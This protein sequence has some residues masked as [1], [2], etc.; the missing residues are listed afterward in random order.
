MAKY[1]RIAI[2]F[3]FIFMV[4]FNA[5]AQSQTVVNG[6]STT[7]INF[8]GT[9]CRYTWVNNNQAIGLA[10]SGTGNIAS[11][12]AV[13]KGTTPITATITA[14]PAAAGY[15]YIPNQVDNTVSVID[16]STNVVIKTIAVGQQP[17]G[18]TIAPDG[19]KAYI[20]NL[21]SKTL[22]VINT[23]TNTVT[24][25]IPLIDSKTGAGYVLGDVGYLPVTG[26]PTNTTISP[27]G[28]YV[29]VANSGIAYSVNT[30][31]N[32][33]N[34]TGKVNVYVL[35]VI[36][37]ATGEVKMIS[38]AVNPVGLC[39][40][41]DGTILYV[42]NGDSNVIS[43]IDI[44]KT[45]TARPITITGS[46][47]GSGSTTLSNAGVAVVLAN[48]AVPINPTNNNPGANGPRNMV[49]SPDGRRLYTTNT[50]S[51]SVSVVNTATYA[52]ISNINLSELPLGICISPDGSKLYVARQ[53]PN[54][55]TVI[56]TAD[57]SIAKTYGPYAS[58]TTPSLSGISLSPDGNFLY[59]ENSI[60]NQVIAIDVSS[61]G[62]GAANY[63]PVGQ[64][65]YVIGNFVSSGSCS[66]SAVTFTITVN[67]VAPT[68]SATGTLSALRTVYGTASTSTQLNVSG[69]NLTAGILVTPPNGFEVSTD[70]IHFSNTVTIGTTGSIASTPVY[71]R[72]AATSAAGNYSG[73]ITLSSA[74]AS[75]VTVNTAA[76]TVV[77]ASLTITANN[78]SKTYG[79]DNPTLTLSYAG[80][81]NGDNSAKLTSPVIATTTA[82]ATSPTGSYPI[83]ASGAAIA[84]YTITYV[85][86]TLTITP[87]PAPVITSVTPAT[88]AAGTTV[89]LAGSNLLGATAVA[90]GGK[91]ASSFTV[92][93]AT[94][95]TAVVAVGASNGLSVTTATGTGNFTGFSFVPIPTISA[96]GLTTVITGGSVVLTASPGTGGYTYQW[97]K[98]G[99]A[100]NGAT[101]A[102]YTATAGGAYTVALTLNN[103]QQVSAAITVNVTFALPVSNFKITNTSVTCK[104][105]NNGTIGITATQNLNY[106]A[107]ITGN[108]LNTTYPFTTSATISNLAAGTYN[109]CLTV[110]GQPGYQQCF[111]SV[112][113]EPKDLSLYSTIIKNTDQAVLS[114]SGADTYYITLNGVTTATTNNQL[115]VTLKNGVNT[116]AVSSDKPCQGLVTENVVIADRAVPF[117]NPFT[118]IINVNLGAEI[119]KK[120]DITIYNAFNKVVH[121]K[122]FK[123]Q[124]GLVQIDAGQLSLGAFFLQ[125][126]ADGQKTIFKMIKK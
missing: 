52:V 102:N 103:L 72:L 91:P 68:I 79:A 73:N 6:A 114:L 40:S 121:S 10:A 5:R 46:S 86:G 117:P 90:F 120:A 75:N 19:S 81:V 13:N 55:V 44:K 25:T 26:I 2:A 28:K 60:S 39:F 112:I 54:T 96:S 3:L 4:S 110:A 95:I 87:A 42:S 34:V 122:T 83:T 45:P 92:N 97:L 65:P 88:A 11:F 67:P 85:N 9:G 89:T 111:T 20:T 61:T 27:D 93:S 30:V 104:G 36:D 98:D 80:F 1:L 12:T 47:A 119:V 63:I 123:N 58:N 57:N 50:N 16:L 77:P 76:S 59:V 94:S 116:L 74:G 15:A 51:G 124:S 8:T 41:P 17:S 37:T 107:T 64:G 43:V 84:N 48:F 7:A 56:N 113:T 69:A 35:Y 38:L 99:V 32:N 109:V 53:Y 66:G 118:S 22:S 101:S 78:Q 33:N 108:G 105:S 49:L 100:I 106:T 23:A 82:T 125:L 21:G 115:T 62:N 126:S 24:A 31:D 70:N 29:Y 14:T 71:V 18:V